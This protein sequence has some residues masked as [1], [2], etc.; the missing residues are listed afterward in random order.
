[1]KH[2]TR[3]MRFSETYQT[4]FDKNGDK[5]QVWNKKKEGKKHA[6]YY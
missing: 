4:K 6:R 2:A 3:Q 5:K 1:M